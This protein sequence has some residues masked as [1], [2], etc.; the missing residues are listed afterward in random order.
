MMKDLRGKLRNAHAEEVETLE[1][2]YKGEEMYE[3]LIR[4]IKQRKA[5]L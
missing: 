4:S 1:R 2:K 5:K 3:F